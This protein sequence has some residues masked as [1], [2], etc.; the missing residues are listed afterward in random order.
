M[1]TQL[2]YIIMPRVIIMQVSCTKI[3]EMLL[4]GHLTEV[5][6]ILP[7][8]KSSLDIKIDDAIDTPGEYEMVYYLHNEAF[9][10]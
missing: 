8:S 9:L 4:G 7:N 5:K 3:T 1:V 10:G 6:L 2:N